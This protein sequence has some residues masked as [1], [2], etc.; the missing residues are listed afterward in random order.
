MKLVD[1]TPSEELVQ[2]RLDRR[3]FLRQ[4]GLTGFGIAAAGVAG[5]SAVAQKTTYNPT[6]QQKD[7]AN[8]IF[9]AALIAEDL[10][11]TFYYNGLVGGVIQDPALAGPG[12]SANSVTSQGNLGNVQYIQAALS[13]EIAH[14]NLFRSLLG[15]SYPHQDPVQTFYFPKGSF[16]TLAAFTGLLNALENAFIGAYLN[17]IQEFAFKAQAYPVIQQYPNDPDNKFT[18]TQ[19]E[20]FAKVAASIMGVECEHRVLGRVISNSNPANN[21]NYQQNSGITAVYNG[22]TSAVVALT[23]FLTPSTG[24]AYSLNTALSNQ[25]GVSIP[26]S[27]GL[28]S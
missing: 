21:L 12:G 6:D 9:T 1:A 27:G 3:R 16:D 4:A 13:E 18:V 15:L 22:P 17:A 7:T 11:T 23:P 8:E 19:F 26:V 2:A 24:P 10:A 14:A 5:T 20:Y 28:P 25:A